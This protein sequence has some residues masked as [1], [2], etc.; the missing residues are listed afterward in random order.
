MLIVNLP[1]LFYPIFVVGNLFNGNVIGGKLSDFED[2]AKLA[3]FGE[4]D[5]AVIKRII[6]GNRTLIGDNEDWAECAKSEHAIVRRLTAQQGK[7]L[8]VLVGDVDEYTRMYVAENGYKLDTL[9]D[10]ASPIVKQAVISAIAKSGQSEASKRRKI[11]KLVY[12]SSVS[13]RMA[14]INAGYGYDKLK[15]DSSWEVRK[16]IASKGYALEHF[17]VDPHYAVR[18]AVA[19]QGFGARRLMK[20][21]S[22]SVR[23]RL[24]KAGFGIKTLIHDQSPLVREAIALAGF[25]LRE[26]LYDESPIVRAAVAEYGFGLQKLS[27]DTSEIVRAKVAQKGYALSKLSKDENWFVRLCAAKSLYQE[28][29]FSKLKRFAKDEDKRV[30]EFAST[31]LK[32]IK[33]K[34]KRQAA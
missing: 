21:K 18:E 22:P 13:V 31:T 25:N 12:D 7:A 8:N 19:D 4:S 5:I 3:G 28:N 10:D 11:Q 1:T 34:E 20:D 16:L 32:Q 26:Y 15:N 14:V 24:V 30:R 23:A 33:D 2:K 29:Q 27:C 17:I 9:I 6:N